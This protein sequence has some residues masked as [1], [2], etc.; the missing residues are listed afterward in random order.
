M[1]SSILAAG[2]R[3]LRRKL[4]AQQPS[5]DSDE[6]LLHTFMTRRDDSA[7]A[8]LVRR[9]GPMVLHV[10]RRVLGHEQDAEDA[11]QAT[12]LV[13]AQNAASLRN[14]ASLAS[15]LHGTAYRTAMKAKQSAAR[16]RK[17]EGQAPAR[18]Q[19]DPAAELSWCEVRTLLDE[20][21][22]R[23]PEKY[24]IVF[25]VFYLED[26][27]REET[28]RRLGLTD[29][30]VA[31]RLTEARKR[32]GRRLAR[33]GVE[34]TAALSAM[35]LA[36][37]SASALPAGLTATTIKAALATA[38]GEGLAGIVSASVAELVK[39]MTTAMMVSKAKTATMFLVT[40]V[41]LAG[42]GAWTCHTLATPRSAEQPAEPPA[43][44]SRTEQGQKAQTPRKEQKDSIRVMGRVLDP[45][46]QPVKGARL[47]WPRLPKNEPRTSEDVE[48]IDIAERAKSDAE[49]C[50]RFELPRSDIHPEWRNV[51]LL[52]VADGYG[53]DGV[54]L[55]KEGPIP[56]VTLRLA[57]AQPIEGRILST[58][59]KPLAGV[60]VRIMGV[61]KP[62][63]ERLDDF[64]A[65]WK[66]K[67]LRATNRA[68]GKLS[69]QMFPPLNEKSFQAVTDKDG[70]FRLQGVGI[71]R[72]A[73]LR[74]RAPGLTPTPLFVVNRAGF[75]PAPWNKAARDNVP[76]EERRP[77][78]P[79][80]LY[81]PKIE[82]VAPAGRRIEGTVREAG[83]GKPVPGYRIT[84]NVPNGFD[85]SAVSD[86]EGKYKL[87]GVPKMK[88]HM[89]SAY[90]PANSAWLPTA[91]RGEDAAGLQPL[92]VDFTVARGVVVRGRVLDRA[93]GQGVY[94]WVRFV[95]LPGN[96]FF[97]KP[98]YD[99]YKY[100]QDEP[101][102]TDLREAGRYQL[103]VLP[104]PGVLMVQARGDP[105]IN[106]G[107]LYKQAEFDAKDCER[108]KI[109]ENDRSFLTALDNHSE[110]LAIQ[111][112]VK[113]LDLA[114]GTGPA[115]CDVFVERGQRRTLRIEDADG[116][117][118]TGTSVGGVTATWPDAMT[119]KDANCTIFALD[120][121]SPRRLFFYHAQRRLVGTLLLRGD[122]KEPVVVR[123]GRA[124]PVIGRL[125]TN[126]GQPLAGADI[127]LNWMDAI[128][129]QL[130]GG[131]EKRPKV[132]TDKEGRFRFE[133][134][135]PELKFQLG[136]IRGET[137]FLGEPPIGTRQVKAGATLD[138][139]DVRV[140]PAR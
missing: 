97:G 109:T 72:L 138:L 48:S 38:A 73:L 89:L 102:K 68:F 136:I 78:R 122:E 133:G 42:A 132:R 40:A 125:L 128:A 12:F 49:G 118:L 58:E 9:H 84:V 126:D 16:R 56:E 100:A 137:I 96:T 110:S 83:S 81:G 139:G 113:V 28:A 130:Y 18:R 45:D 35:A 8:A 93:T 112:A 127:Y 74:F 23:L 61:G 134:I 103:A 24:R 79:P 140:K 105:K 33:R 107:N 75:D 131:V 94:A 91:A 76:P 20:E 17:H 52:A 11:F 26:H 34:L 106:G 85:I 22:A 32:L 90:P 111:N 43:S 54:E 80:L 27:S 41:L 47:Y 123:L 1:S 117:P 37:Q 30:A 95:P 121:K 63:Q 114:P 101:T 71:E 5:S 29:A 60:S 31:K 67:D 116:K 115:K 119:V 108:F 50:F 62:R 59:G 98:G 69:Q 39:G 70:R 14:K 86:S 51:C 65:A 10:C 44:P 55:P 4:A 57:K 66:Q 3:H 19:T 129:N 2:L 124:T 13:L 53:M 25:V 92:Q 88:E 120:P 135:V 82:Y 77:D 87:L 6:Q 21:I 64:L 46:G 36:Q 99:Y 7:F 15:F 104:G